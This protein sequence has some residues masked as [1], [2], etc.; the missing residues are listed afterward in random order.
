VADIQPRLIWIDL[1]TLGL[2]PVV[3]PILEVAIAEA[4][5]LDPFNINHIYHAV[6]R[7]DPEDRLWR[8]AD[9]DGFVE[10]MHTKN[11]LLVESAAKGQ[12]LGRVV[13]DLFDLF[14]LIEDYSLRPILTGSSVHFDH[15][16]L[17]KWMPEIAD[18]FSH[19]HY[20]V[21]AI[22]LFCQSL[23]M[24]KIPKA[25]AHRAKAD[26][27]ESVAHAKLCRDWLVGRGYSAAIRDVSDR[28]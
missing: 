3:A 7:L 16:F 2:D 20:D 22:K 25:E 18:R 9:R 24:E 11:G 6:L 5:L 10:K 1:E 4:D 21:S 15:G 27:E 13:E 19:R 23:G 12:R 28:Q 14:P 26:I 17:K 8:L